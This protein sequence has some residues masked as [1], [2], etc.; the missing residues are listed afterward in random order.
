VVC[1]ANLLCNLTPINQYPESMR[2]APGQA[3]PDF[4]VVDLDGHSRNLGDYRG[5]PLLLQFYRYSGCPMCDLRLHDFAR[6]YPSL[7][8]DGL[9]VIAFFH[10]SAPRL[11]RHFARRP[12]PFP[13]VGDSDW[14]T[15]RSFGVEQSVWRFLATM[16]KPSFYV[17]W[18]RSLM[19]GFWGAFDLRMDVMPADFLIDG[20]GV[21]RLAHYGRDFGDH[22]TTEELRA[23][24][25]SPAGLYRRLGTR[26]ASTS[27]PD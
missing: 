7:A 21:V 17:D 8:G 11:R 19:L 5:R 16:L 14:Q 4:T 24:I 15:Y 10:S 20:D 3:A 6:D 12:M 1:T 9:S 13:I 26:G 25:R 22:L 27:T 2:I 23:W 18:A